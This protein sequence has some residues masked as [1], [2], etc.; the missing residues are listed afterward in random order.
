MYKPWL[1]SEKQLLLSC[2]HCKFWMS[3]TPYYIVVRCVVTCNLCFNNL[4][5]CC[6]R[7]GLNR[8]ESSLSLIFSFIVLSQ[9]RLEVCWTCQQGWVWR[10]RLCPKVHTAAPKYTLRW[11]YTSKGESVE[12]LSGLL[13]TV[14]SNIH[15]IN[16]CVQ[17]KVN[18]K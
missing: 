5:F 3:R 2:Y 4:C 12:L 16:T 11:Q 14:W 1:F 18:W 15:C 13:S 6:Y 9:T 10:L 8:N 17:S 7:I